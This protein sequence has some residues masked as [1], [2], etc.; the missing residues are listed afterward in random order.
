M[1]S[2]S[3]PLAPG[4]GREGGPDPF[5]GPLPGPG[6]LASA[7]RLGGAKTLPRGQEGPECVQ[8]TRSQPLDSLSAPFT[9]VDSSGLRAVFGRCLG[10]VRA[11]F[12]RCSGGVRAVLEGAGN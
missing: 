8:S 12:G 6:R 11:M 4:G 1:G 5:R 9:W 3:A 10:G 7:A 2:L